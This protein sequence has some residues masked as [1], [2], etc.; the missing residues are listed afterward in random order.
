[1]AW[2]EQLTDDPRLP[3]ACGNRNQTYGRDLDFAKTIIFEFGIRHAFSQDMVFDVSAYNKDKV[4]DV[5]GRLFRLP[6]PGAGGQEGDWRVF[7]NA[8]FG[9][10]R[11]LDFRLDRRFS[12]IFSGSVAYT[13]QV[14]KST[15]SDP[16]AYFRTTARI[17][18]NAVLLGPGAGTEQPTPW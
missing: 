15:G 6:D 18:L 4:A 16:F 12:N 7:N 10:V 5:S 9:N 14:A 13:F 11:G 2:R 1:M 17:L 8:D 3:Y